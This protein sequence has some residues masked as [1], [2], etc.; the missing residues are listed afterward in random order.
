MCHLKA[1]ERKGL[2]IRETGR[3]RAIRLANDSHLG[4]NFS[5]WT[6]DTKRG[7]DIAS[8]LEAGTVGVND[9]YAATWSSYDAPMGGMNASG[10]GRRHGAPGLLKYTESQTVSVQRV[11]PAFAPPPGL[12][13]ESYV[14]VLKPALKLLRRLPFYK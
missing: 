11:I 10:M 3:S 5:V 12:S 8:R 13:Y 6:R 9:G 4:L 7:V 2:I 14:K 1:L